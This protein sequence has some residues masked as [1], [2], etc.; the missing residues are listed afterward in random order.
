MA[1][2][3]DAPA[4]IGCVAGSGLR[5]IA[6][7]VVGGA[8]AGQALGGALEGLL[9]GVAPVDALTTT[10]SI[11]ALSSVGLLAA[12]VPAWRATRIDPL[13]ILRRG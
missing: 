10:V 8:I 1:M 11:V 13:Q 3:A 5:L 9:F 7:G 6:L 4:V 12:L 2:G